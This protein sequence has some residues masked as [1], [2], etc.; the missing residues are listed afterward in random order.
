MK[1]SFNLFAL[2][3][4]AG[5]PTAFAAE[6]APATQT[7]HNIVDLNMS[8]FSK[9]IESQE[10]LKKTDDNGN[11]LLHVLLISMKETGTGILKY[12]MKLT[13]LLNKIKKSNLLDL[14]NAINKQGSTPLDLV[15]PIDIDDDKSPFSKQ[16]KKIVSLL[17][18]HGA[19]RSTKVTLKKLND[20]VA[21]GK[22]ENIDK[23]FL[24]K[25]PSKVERKQVRKVFFKN[26]L[27]KKPDGG[28]APLH[29]AIESKSIPMINY[30]LSFKDI[31]VN[32]AG[33][34]GNTPL[35]MA[36]KM[37]GETGLEIIKA[38]LKH[39]KIDVNQPDLVGKTPLDRATDKKII[40]S[41]QRA[42][43]REEARRK[44]LEKFDSPLV[45]LTTLL[46]KLKE[47]LVH[48]A[49]ELENI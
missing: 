12:Q 4:L 39:K 9:K 24:Q 38:L 28:Q 26:N 10:I 45:P 21:T 27:N 3:W 25:Y 2:L 32:I 43:Q 1:T 44:R 11:T 6:P 8:E 33:L 19:E 36:A 47:K 13:P 23:L 49:N 31:D 16:V 48:V 15:Y 40:E 34:Y 29:Y 7:L 46:E 20:A 30:L 37:T 41:L 42:Q 18:T 17:K 14:I 22:P 35:H 5:F